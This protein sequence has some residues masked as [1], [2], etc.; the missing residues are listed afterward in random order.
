LQ[1]FI[2]VS[3]SVSMSVLRIREYLTF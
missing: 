3:K 1:N 2:F